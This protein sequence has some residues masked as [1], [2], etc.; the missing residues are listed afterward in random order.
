MENTLSKQEKRKIREQK[1]LTRLLKEKNKNKF[2]GYIFYFLFI[3]TVV[4]LVDEISTNIGK[5]MELDVTIF[6][7]KTEEA[8]NNSSIRSLVT[9][10]ITVIAGTSMFLR[11]LADRFGR[12]LFLV[13]YTM[14][15]GVAMFIISVSNHIAGWVVGTLLI[16]MCIPHDMQQVYI[17]ECA[18]KEKRGTYFFVIKGIATLSLMIVPLLRKAFNVDSFDENF[19]YVYL[20]IGIIGVTAAVLAIFLMRESDVYLDSRISWLQKSDEEKAIAKQEKADEARRSGIF[21]GIAYMFKHKQLLFLL[22]GMCLVMFTYVLTD[23]YNTIM[24]C[25]W[26]QNQGKEL[27]VENYRLAKFISTNAVLIYPIGCGL[28]VLT[29][30]FISDKIG[31]KKASIF[32]GISA[33]TCYI[34]FF[35]GS[36]NVWSPYLLGFL[37]GAACG[38]VWSYGDL[39]LLMVT[40]SS[41]TNMRVSANA[42]AL[43]C[44]GIFYTIGQTIIGAIGTKLGD[45]Y[46]GIATIVAVIIGL[47][48]G[49]ILILITV[50]E[51]KG[52]DLTEVKA[53]NFEGE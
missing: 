19:K 32:Y 53:A 4:Y 2:V 28:V 20:I 8:Y 22:L 45:G 18:P 15:M 31:R 43:C 26:L 48:L 1:E 30:G 38:S 37:I 21:S 25:G 16:Q 17:Q 35:I 42:V 52:V 24:S 3:I 34:L 51:T 41:S 23:N 39:I 10:L 27:T 6:F 33:L 40:E 44:A 46:L 5:F 11:P 36:R 14:G 29:P 50:K 13:I 12:K 7:F 9:T 49:T 47:T